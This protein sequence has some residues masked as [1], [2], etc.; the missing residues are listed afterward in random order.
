M[1]FFVPHDHALN[2]H[3]RYCDRKTAKTQKEDEG[4]KEDRVGSV[5]LHPAEKG[6][7]AGVIPAG[8]EHV[9]GI[10]PGEAPP[11]GS[12]VEEQGDEVQREEYQ[13]SLESGAHGGKNGTG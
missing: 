11:M 10:L 2:Q 1:A 5:G 7:M 9:E 12:L 4:S 6:D 3:H 13:E 8:I